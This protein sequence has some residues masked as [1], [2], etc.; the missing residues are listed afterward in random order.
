MSIAGL[1]NYTESLSL[2]GSITVKNNLNTRNVFVNGTLSGSGISSNILSK[3][4]VWTGTNTYTN[5][6]TYSGP[7]SPIDDNDL[8]IKQDVDNLVAS[9]NPLP[10][11]NFWNGRATF[12]GTVTTPN[13]SVSDNKLLNAT[14]CDNFIANFQT[15]PGSISNTFSGNNQFN[16]N[17]TV[18][19]IP[20]LLIPT[21]DNQL[22]SKVYVDS[23]IEVSGKTLTY[24][25]LTPGSYNFDFVN[26]DNIIGI[27]FLL[28]GGSVNNTHSGAMYSGK[29]GNGNGQ[30]SSL[31]LKVG[32]KD[33]VLNRSSIPPIDSPSNTYIKSGYEYL[34]VAG[35]AYILNGN[36]QP[37]QLY[38]FSSDLTANIATFGRANA[39]NIFAYSN[40]LGTTNSNGG[41][42]FV[43]YYK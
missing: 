24:T 32:I 7:I 1:Q 35:G 10:T 34:G 26:R 4:N 36:A 5:T 3:N 15:I 19:N 17:I 18:Q 38:G 25:V 40:I 16:N 14:Q 28:F 29:I 8:T 37:G 22:A 9:Y 39:P 23:K 33:D 11:D 31:F 27:E 6:T 41:A 2:L 13:T 21:L 30:I 12:S 20:S 42:I 43:A